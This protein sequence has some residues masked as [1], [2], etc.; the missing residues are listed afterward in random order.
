LT[1]L[2]FLFLCQM[3]LCYLFEDMPTVAQ[4]LATVNQYLGALIGSSCIG[5]FHFYD[6]LVQLAN[7]DGELTATANEILDRV[8]AHQE[9]I[10]KWANSAPM[11]YQHKFDLVA[12]EKYR[13]LGEILKSIQKILNKNL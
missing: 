1:G 6:S 7:F 4:H 13:L 10:A 5:V 9:E 11:N 2:A 12:E 3:F 8:N